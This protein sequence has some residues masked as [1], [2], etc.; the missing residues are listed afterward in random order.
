MLR[1]PQPNI[2]AARY[3]FRHSWATIAQN[4][5]GA[6]TEMVAFCLNHSSAHKTT[7]GYIRKDYKPIDVLNE[8]VIKYLS[9]KNKIYYFRNLLYFNGSGTIFAT[10]GLTYDYS[11]GLRLCKAAR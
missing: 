3:A 7:E 10:K 4:H 8:K 6:S 5:C 11:K 1:I 9:Y 2:A